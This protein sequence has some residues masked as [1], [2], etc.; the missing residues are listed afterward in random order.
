MIFKKLLKYGMTIG[1]LIWLIGYTLFV[2]SV[3]VKTPIKNI[4]TTDAIIVLTGGQNRI[5]SALQLFAQSKTDKLF[6]TGV[7]KDV[8]QDDILQMW[9]GNKPL[10][11]CCIILGQKAKTTRGNALEAQEW[12]DQQQNINNIVLVTSAYHMDRALLEFN[13]AL[14]NHK[15]TITPYP[16][17]DNSNAL[18]TPS[19]W[20]LT[21]SEYNKFI[22]RTTV[23]TLANKG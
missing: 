6:I 22:F 3:S 19:F 13:H 23:L 12:I 18:N 10:K 17:M 8:S 21:F 14:Y 9:D 16:V 5:D 7:H 20:K 15:V 2:F 11:K 4:N 1:V